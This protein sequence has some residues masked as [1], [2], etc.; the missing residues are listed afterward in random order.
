M[1]FIIRDD[2]LSYFADPEHLESLY[3]G[4]WDKFP[5]CFSTIP[6]VYTK[7]LEVPIHKEHKKDFYYIYEN[8][9]LVEFLKK[10]IKEGKVKIWLHGFTHR[11]VDGVFDLERRDYDAVYSDLK[12][13]KEILERTFDI[14]ID[15]LVPPHDRLSKEAVNAI[16]DLGIKT[17]CRG[18]AP[19]PREIQWDNKTYIDS[20]YKIF[21]F[22]IRY[23]RGLRYPIWLNFG[24]HYEIF[25]YRIQHITRD[26]LDKILKLHNVKGG[27]FCVTMHYRAISLY[28]QEMLK[29]IIKKLELVK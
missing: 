24:K 15:T 18:F 25:S 12:K 8:K 1:E 3:N 28:Q 27:I 21:I 9:K 5:V 13:G 29:Y 4:I 19:L 20:Y 10:K 22:W 2:D 26:N 16:E 11:D 6:K 14:K 17:I 7:Q 23:G